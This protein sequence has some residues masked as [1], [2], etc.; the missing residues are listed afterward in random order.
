MRR[1][2]LIW[3]AAGAGTA[4]LGAVAAWLLV[5]R[6]EAVETYLIVHQPLAGEI[7]DSVYWAQKSGKLMHD[8]GVKE[9]FFRT[10]GA[11]HD[12]PFALAKVNSLIDAA[13]AC[14]I[15]KAAEVDARISLVKLGRGQINGI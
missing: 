3:F 11:P 7:R 14:V 6:H 13:S 8:C 10:E 5:P 15:S 9:I 2:R 1:T 4:A 12:G